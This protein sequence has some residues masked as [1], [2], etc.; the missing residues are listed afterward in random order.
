MAGCKGSVIQTTIG[1]HDLMMA[2]AIGRS[3]KNDLF[4]SAMFYIFIV[5]LDINF[6]F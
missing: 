6:V 3:N 2:S 4:C 5:I 1:G